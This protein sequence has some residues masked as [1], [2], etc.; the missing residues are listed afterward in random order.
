[1]E[2]DLIGQRLVHLLL[3]YWLTLMRSKVSCSLY[4]NFTFMAGYGYFTVKECI[5]IVSWVILSIIANFWSPAVFL[6]AM[7]T[8]YVN[9]VSTGEYWS[10]KPEDMSSTYLTTW[11]GNER[12]TGLL[13]S[14]LLVFSSQKEMGQSW[15]DLKNLFVYEFGISFHSLF[16]W[17]LTSYHLRFSSISFL[18]LVVDKLLKHLSV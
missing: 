17:S 13:Q 3:K 10:L 11:I 4:G 2:Q 12:L 1:M 9:P 18:K 7:Q 14:E 6:Q 16:A 8:S 15:V 5:H